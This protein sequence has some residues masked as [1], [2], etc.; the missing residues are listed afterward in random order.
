MST[1][2]AFTLRPAWLLARQTL[3]SRGGLAILVG[4]IGLELLARYALP[5]GVAA[6]HARADQIA[7]ESR[8]LL[9]GCVTLLVLLRAARWRPAIQGLGDL[10]IATT[11]GLSAIYVVFICWSIVGAIDALLLRTTPQL[12]GAE[13]VAAT[14]LATLAGVLALSRLDSRALGLGFLLLAWWV[15]VLGLP[16]PGAGGALGPGICG[17]PWSVERILPMLVPHLWAVGYVCLE[18]TQR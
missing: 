17:A 8:L 1:L 11:V 18:R 2:R 7:S 13:L 5:F 12:H 15:P 3:A 10:G 6:S 14:W 9:A 4:I 16:V